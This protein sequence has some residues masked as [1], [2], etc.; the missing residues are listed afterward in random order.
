M[1]LAQRDIHPDKGPGGLTRNPNAA[2]GVYSP[3]GAWGDPTLAT[4]EKGRVY[5]EALL[6]EIA[7]AIERL[8]TG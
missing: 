3:T 7:A 5:I 2:S 8:R 1:N 6:N 4:V